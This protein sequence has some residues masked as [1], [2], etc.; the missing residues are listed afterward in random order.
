MVKVSASAGGARGKQL[1]TL[2]SY[3]LT[4]PV[5]V[6]LDA[7]EEDA[8]WKQDAIRSGIQVW[9]DS[10]PDSPFVLAKPGEKPMIAVRFV[11]G[12]GSS[13]DV[14]GQV[15]STR[16]LRWGSQVSYRIEATLQVK[17]STGRRQ[18]RDVEFTEV[19]AHELGHVLGL[20]D[21]SECVGLMGPFVPGHARP[22]PSR[23]EIRAVLDYR[24]QLRDAI[25]KLGPANK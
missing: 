22:A 3:L 21:N 14:Q 24:D 15:E 23:E 18:L 19:V 16:Y 1:A 7:G 13:G 25:A 6:G 8:D 4:D 11:N 10:I 2:K 12:I 20:D 17:V 5:T 9:N